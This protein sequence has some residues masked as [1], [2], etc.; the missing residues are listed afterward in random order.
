MRCK[1][2]KCRG[3]ATKTWAMV[4]I[5]DSCYEDIKTETNLYYRRKIP[6]DERICHKQLQYVKR[7]DKLCRG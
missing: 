7:A 2:P 4:P 6:M 5:C 3:I 1:M